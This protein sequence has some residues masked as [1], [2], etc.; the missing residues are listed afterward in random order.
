MHPSSLH[1]IS[2]LNRTVKNMSATV[3]DE[4]KIKNLSL[5]PKIL[6]ETFQWVNPKN[7]PTNPTNIPNNAINGTLGK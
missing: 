3:I 6:L 4:H 7:R 5:T 2:L 1:P